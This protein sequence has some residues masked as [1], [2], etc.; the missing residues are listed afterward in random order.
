MFDNAAVRNRQQNSDI[1]LGSRRTKRGDVR[2]SSPS[3]RCNKFKVLK[4]L[5]NAL[6]TRHGHQAH[7]SLGSRIC[8]NCRGI[9]QHTCR[10]MFD[11]GPRT[12]QRRVPRSMAP[13][14]A[15]LPKSGR[16]PRTMVYVSQLHARSRP[17]HRAWAQYTELPI[18]ALP[19]EQ[20]IDTNETGD[21]DC[22]VCFGTHD[23][24]V[25]RGAQLRK[26]HSA[27]RHLRL[28]GRDLTEG[29]CSGFHRE[30]LLLGVD[31]D[32]VL[33]TAVIHKEKT[34]ELPDN[35]FTVGV[36]RLRYAE[37]LCQLSFWSAESMSPR[38]RATWNATFTSGRM[39]TS[40][41]CCQA[42]RMWSRMFA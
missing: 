22:P 17:Y 36:K 23:G 27:S 24:R 8:C 41:S 18:I 25:V 35:V 29:Y 19:E 7:C 1:N 9:G 12:G 34:N 26:L 40:M 28:G 30:T 4:V 16:M 20:P 11:G 14:I 38:S 39:S 10:K 13:E 15:A 6:Q 21:P 3:D 32:T 5:L 37:V 31:Y 42:A 33:T 2:E